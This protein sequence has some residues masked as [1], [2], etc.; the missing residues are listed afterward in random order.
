MDK[1]TIQ[2]GIFR[3]YLGIGS[4]LLGMFLLVTSFFL[5]YAYPALGV[6]PE[7]V[8]G[9]GQLFFLGSTLLGLGV[10]KHVKLKSN[11][12]TSPQQRHEYEPG[13]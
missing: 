11:S 8:W 4:I 9:V 1:R 12:N 7:L 13:D 2:D 10:Y 3:I 6:F 5:F